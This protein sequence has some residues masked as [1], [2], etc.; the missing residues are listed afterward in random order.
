MQEEVENWFDNW[1]AAEEDDGGNLGKALY[2]LRHTQHHLG[3]LGVIA[4]LVGVEAPDWL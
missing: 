4:R 2:F 1:A 3:E